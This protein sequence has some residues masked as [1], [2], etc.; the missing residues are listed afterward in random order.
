MNTIIE[1]VNNSLQTDK[2]KKENSIITNISDI[3][4][5][6]DNNELCTKIKEALSP[7]ESIDSLKPKIHIPIF[8]LHECSITKEADCMSEEYKESI[9]SIIKNVQMHISKSR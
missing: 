9:I 8:L 1:S 2:L 6:I 5:L 4:S 3:D 7:Q